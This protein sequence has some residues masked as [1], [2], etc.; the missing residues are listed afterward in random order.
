MMDKL[1]EKA[2]STAST[3]LRLQPKGKIKGFSFRKSFFVGM[4]DR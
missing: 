3:W 1:L 4:P 2:F